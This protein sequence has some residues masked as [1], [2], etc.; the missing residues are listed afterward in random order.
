[1]FYVWIF[2]VVFSVH[3]VRGRECSG[4][5]CGDCLVNEGCTWCKDKEFAF[6]RCGALLTILKDGCTEI[7]K[8]KAHTVDILENNDF[9]DGGDLGQ[10]AVQL[11]PQ[12]IKIK[13]IPN[14]A[15]A[16]VMIHYKIARNFPLDIYFLIDP[17]MNNLIA[18]LF[19]LTSDIAK[20][21][22]GLTTDFRFGFG[23]AKDKVTSCKNPKYSQ[24]SCE[25]PPTKCI[26]PDS[27]LHRQ[28]LISDVSAFKNALN[29]TVNQECGDNAL[30]Q[31]E[32]LDTVGGLFNGLVQVMA[33]GDRIGWRK[34]ARRMIIYATDS[35][36][37]QAG[38]GR[39]AGILEPNDGLCH[40]DVN[41]RYIKSEMQ[42]YPSVGQLIMK[43]RENNMNVI[44]VFGG[45]NN[46]NIRQGYYDGLA[47]HFPGR[48]G[49]AFPLGFDSNDILSIIR[50]SYRTLH[51]TV[52]LSTSRGPD[53][54]NLGIYTNCRTEGRI[55]D[56]T[57][58]CENLA[59][60]EWANFSLAFRSNLSFCPSKRLFN[61]T[62]Y[63]EG[64]DDRVEIEVEHECQCDCQRE[65]EAKPNSTNC[66]QRG[67]YECGVCHCNEGWSGDS[68]LC[69]QRG[70]D[71]EAC[72]TEAGICSNAGICT[73]R[74]CVCFEGY[75]GDRCECNNHICPTHNRSLCGGHERGKCSC[76]KCA[77]TAG[78][79]GV[80]CECP[81]SVETC[82][83]Q[84]GT[85]CSD[86]GVCECGKCRCDEGFRG[87]MCEECHAC[88]GSCEA[89]YNCIECVSFKQG[90]YNDTM[91]KDRCHNINTVP[92]LYYEDTNLT[93]DYKHC[94]LQDSFGCIIHFN[95]YNASNNQTI[96]VKAMKRCPSR[97]IDAI[98]IGLSISGAVLLA[99][100]V[101]VIIW[102]ILT[103]LYDNAEYTELE[104]EMKNPI[105]ERC[106]DLVYME[107]SSITLRQNK[108]HDYSKLFSVENQINYEEIDQT[109]IDLYL[110]A[111][112]PEYNEIGMIRRSS[113]S[114]HLLHKTTESVCSADENQIDLHIDARSSEYYEIGMIRSSSNLDQLLYKTIKSVHFADKNQDSND[115]SSC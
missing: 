103:L 68:C 101:L 82:R 30:K 46:T 113:N 35:N 78:Y 11:K 96:Q 114:D 3:S 53:E 49:N 107:G 21:I 66:N 15:L 88:P 20:E 80:M 33:C 47:R 25:K 110:D 43:A 44:F 23:T 83:S 69:D 84:N 40:L 10:N 64:L 93:E 100:F 89:N 99:G 45:V 29:W 37:H 63:P 106:E 62:I 76:G 71:T 73:C 8:R 51:R 48:I 54:L 105:W 95:V 70:T 98:L 9:S 34:K 27:F 6:Q 102:K 74:R 94:I 16:Y 28:P 60:N 18:S 32:D 111:I 1:M 108:R 26:T 86:R 67:T 75:S 42:D 50:D 41:G 61:M 39:I 7:V 109:R 115:Q 2:I 58:L 22:S 72:G 31:T 36:Y 57:N 14:N 104:S 92:L 13:L 12:R 79:S 55:L 52:K 81:K 91:C 90:I 24:K 77:C 59:V 112:T 87:T 56:K 85:I 65:P 17:S 5:R 97:P 4:S 38:D 19:E